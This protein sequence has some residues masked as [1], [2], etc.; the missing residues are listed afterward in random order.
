MILNK[1]R[2]NNLLKVNLVARDQNIENSLGKEIKQNKLWRKIIAKLKTAKYIEY[3]HRSTG[4][5]LKST[6]MSELMFKFIRE[7]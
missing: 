2:A 4:P 5:S 1:T 3:K 7:I 6:G